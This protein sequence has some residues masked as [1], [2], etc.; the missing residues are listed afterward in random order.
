MPPTPRV[1]QSHVRWQRDFLARDAHP[2]AYTPA[3]PTLGVGPRP[4][5]AAPS[6]GP[7][8]V[9]AASLSPHGH[10][11][12][13]VWSRPITQEHRLVYLV[14]GDDVVILQARFHDE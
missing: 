12:A 4:E 2:Q 13:G 9:F 3:G 14:D 10:V 1:A 11:L 5:Y 6:A 7:S 8:G